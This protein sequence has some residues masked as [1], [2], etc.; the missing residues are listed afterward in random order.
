MSTVLVNSDA[1]PG[2]GCEAGV[3]HRYLRKYRQTL[4]VFPQTLFHINALLSASTVNLT[5]AVNI[6][7]EDPSMAAAVLRS[8]AADAEIFCDR[9]LDAVVALGASGLRALMLRTPIMTR[10]EASSNLCRAW[11]NHSTLTSALAEAIA[12]PCDPFGA[13]VVGTA[14]LLHDIGKLPTILRQEQRGEPAG[15]KGVNQS[16]TKLPTEHCCIGN[17]LAAAW[18]LARPVREAILLHHDDE[19]EVRTWIVAVVRAADRLAH[20]YGY[21]LDPEMTRNNDG[22]ADAEILCAAL[23][24]LSDEQQ[25]F[26]LGAVRHAHDEWQRLHPGELPNSKGESI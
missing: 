8:A 17:S 3:G 13:A 16:G 21:G 9:L 23:P 24:L 7:A 18:N 6:V 22:P 2:A 26:C 25:S 4:P 14:G 20:C 10:A 11:R 5:R 19:T 12:A 15:L 1:A